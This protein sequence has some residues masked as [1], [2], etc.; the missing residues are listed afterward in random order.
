MLRHVRLANVTESLFAAEAAV[1]ADCAAGC[2]AGCATSGRA[3]INENRGS[4][5]RA[6]RGIGSREVGGTTKT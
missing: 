6:G 1:C 5:E 4:R 3:L 2:V